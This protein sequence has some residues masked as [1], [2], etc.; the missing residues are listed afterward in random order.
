MLSVQTARELQQKSLIVL[1]GAYLWS[2]T[3]NIFLAG[4]KSFLLSFT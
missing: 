2:A 4:Y 1:L 3:M